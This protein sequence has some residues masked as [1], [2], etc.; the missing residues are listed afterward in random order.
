[1]NGY[2]MQLPEASEDTTRA[3]IA[4]AL[5]SVRAMRASEIA[6]N[7][8]GTAVLP[9]DPLEVVAITDRGLTVGEIA[10]RSGKKIDQIAE[11]LG[12]LTAVGLVQQVGEGPQRRF[13]AGDI[14]LPADSL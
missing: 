4:E 8:S 5:K 7:L 1:M 9:G 14:E 10:S 12:A 11:R 6:A 3:V 13:Y 2:E